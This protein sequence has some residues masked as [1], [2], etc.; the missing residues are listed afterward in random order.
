MEAATVEAAFMAAVSAAVV[1]VTAA[2]LSMAAGF[3]AVMGFAAEAIVTAAFTTVDAGSFTGT[4]FTGA[5]TMRRPITHYGPRKICRYRPWHH[6]WRYRHHRPI[7][8]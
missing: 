3:A 2:P 4:T 1:F 7:Y 6:H 5:S 8:W